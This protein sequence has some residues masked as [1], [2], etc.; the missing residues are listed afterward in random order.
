MHVVQRGELYKMQ[1]LQ[2]TAQIYIIAI[3]S[4]NK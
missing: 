1:K 2:H 4:A 3:F